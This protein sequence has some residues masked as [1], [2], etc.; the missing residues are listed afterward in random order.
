MRLSVS[1]LYLPQVAIGST[2]KTNIRKCRGS[3]KG[4]G[5]LAKRF[6]SEFANQPKMTAKIMMNK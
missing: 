6:L 1:A 5:N 2:N 4:S 3:R